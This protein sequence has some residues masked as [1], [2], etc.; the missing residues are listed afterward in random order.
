M[1]NFG[2]I[3]KELRINKGESQKELAEVLNVTFQSI[4][5][6]EQGIHYP[7]VFMIEKIANHYDVDINYL[8]TNNK[9]IENSFDTMVE[10]FNIRTSIN[11]KDAI[12]TWTDFEYEDSI[13]PVSFLDN[14]RHR[15]GNGLLQTH[16]GPKDYLIICVNDKNKICFMAEH[17]NNRFPICGPQGEFYSQV[18]GIGTNNP[19]FIIKDTY[20]YGKWGMQIQDEEKDFEFVIPENGFL[21][22]IPYYSMEAQQLLLFLM[23]APLIKYVQNS[24]SGTFFNNKRL[25]NGILVAG[26]LDNVTVYLKGK[27]IFFDKKVITK[28]KKETKD[29]TSDD[30]KNLIE[31]LKNTIEDLENTIE[32]LEN[33]IADLELRIEDVEDDVEDLEGRIE[34]VEDSDD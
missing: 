26:S 11:V 14:T 24:F 20:R 18:N 34:E 22:N 25:F 4:S 32:E 23:P 31:E 1:E 9:K 19:C 3:L 8:F 30:V 29:Y 28:Q 12:V 2:S 10:R 17:R 15:A 5:K 7:D 13:A 33:K 16:P 6:W 21:I 27:N